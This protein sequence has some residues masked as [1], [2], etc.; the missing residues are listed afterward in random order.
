MKCLDKIENSFDR[1]DESLVGRN[2][3]SCNESSPVY[4][5]NDKD[6]I[7]ESNSS[8][9]YTCDG[10]GCMINADPESKW[11][12]CTF[13]GDADF[14]FVCCKKDI[15]AEH[16]AYL[17]VFTAPDNRMVPHCEACGHSFSDKNDTLFKCSLCEDYCLCHTC[18]TKLLHVNHSKHLRVTSIATYADEL[19]LT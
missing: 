11:Y 2:N 6:D 5:P 4:E 8:G 14:C 15:H 13:C 3:E 12:G 7:T 1:I 19:G 18:K 16:K 9:T 17:Q 10:C